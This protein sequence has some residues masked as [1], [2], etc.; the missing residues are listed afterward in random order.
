MIRHLQYPARRWRHSLSRLS[1]IC[2]R[3]PY[4]ARYSSVSWN[5]MMGKS[6]LWVSKQHGQRPE[7][8]FRAYVAWTEGAPESEVAVIRE[9]LGMAEQPQPLKKSHS[10]AAAVRVGTQ[11]GTSGWQRRS[12]SLKDQALIGGKGGTRSNLRIYRTMMSP[13]VPFDPRIWHSIWH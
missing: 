11:I 12:K 10:T 13:A 7:T 1:D 8:M 4:N 3:R 9:A 2:Y 6:P 5:L